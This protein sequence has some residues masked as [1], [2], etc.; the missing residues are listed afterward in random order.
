MLDKYPKLELIAATYGYDKV[1]EHERLRD[2]VAPA[3]YAFERG[4]L[5]K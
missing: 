4:D 5:E 2:E 1:E 3:Y